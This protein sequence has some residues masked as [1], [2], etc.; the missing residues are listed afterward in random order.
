MERW[1]YVGLPCQDI[2]IA[3]TPDFWCPRLIVFWIIWGVSIIC[4]TSWFKPFTLAGSIR[5]FNSFDTV[6]VMQTGVS[7]A[8]SFSVGPFDMVVNQWPVVLETQLGVV[9]D[10][11]FYDIFAVIFFFR[12]AEV[13]QVGVLEKFGSRGSF[14]RIKLKHTDNQ[15]NSLVRS[16]SLEPFIERFVFCLTNLLNHGCSIVSC[17]RLNLGSTRFSCE[18]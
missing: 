13:G 10:W 8:L 11:R 3:M 15:F 17:Q 9:A 14:F 12:I 5:S 18:W 6:T 4:V 2:A 1:T 16:S 7:M